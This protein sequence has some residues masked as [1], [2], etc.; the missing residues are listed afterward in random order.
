MNLLP[1]FS[2]LKHLDFSQLIEL[3]HWWV[4]LPGK[5]YIHSALIFWYFFWSSGRLCF[6]FDINVHVYGLLSN[7][8]AREIYLK[9]RTSY[10]PPLVAPT[11]G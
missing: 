8:E 7:R 1:T 9:H 5:Y 2:Y 4:S 11:S 10:V 6:K 3:F